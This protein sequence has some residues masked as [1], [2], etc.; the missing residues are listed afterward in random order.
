MKPDPKLEMIGHNVVLDNGTYTVRGGFS[1][2][3]SARCLVPCML[4][5]A[6]HKVAKTRE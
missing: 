1:S 2:S 4:G 6:R 5:H 3:D